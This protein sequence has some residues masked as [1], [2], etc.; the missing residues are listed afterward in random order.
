MGHARM[1]ITRQSGK[2]FVAAIFLVDLYCLG[3]KDVM[4]GIHKRTMFQA[5]LPA[6]Y[7]DGKPEVI[8]FD[9]ARDIVWGGVQY[10]RSLGFEPPSEFEGEKYLLGVETTPQNNII[11]GGPAGKPLYVVGPQDIPENIIQSL[12]ERLGKDGFQVVYPDEF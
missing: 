2:E 6:V 1:T 10:A 12:E 11:F 7:F 9:L 3:V 8:D 4:G 5:M